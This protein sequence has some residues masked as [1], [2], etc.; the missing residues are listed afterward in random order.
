M[1]RRNYHIF[2]LNSTASSLEASSTNLFRNN[3]IF[4]VWPSHALSS[5]SSSKLVDQSTESTIIQLLLVAMT[6]AV[7]FAGNILILLSVYKFAYM[8]SI[9]SYLVANLAVIDFGLSFLILPTVAATIANQ[10]WM[11][12][13]ALCVS[14]GC[15]DTLLTNAQVMA[16]LAIGVNRY[17]AMLHPQW[18]HSH[19][20]KRLFI[21]FLI[22]GWLYSVLWTIPP[23][24]GWGRYSYAKGTLFC[25][26]SWNETPY[27]AISHLVV[28]Y[29]MPSLT[30]LYFYIGVVRAVFK[31]VQQIGALVQEVDMFEHVANRGSFQYRDEV[32]TKQHFYC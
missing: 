1:S 14:A 26:V 25:G 15:I 31:Y 17:M 30:G 32:K 3:S 19:K 24:L 13:E 4:T 22:G 11:L 5:T 18:Y 16:L 21:G 12:N 20:S 6:M 2:E 10:H 8:R 27:F 23:F 9:S 29:V 7:S 28:S